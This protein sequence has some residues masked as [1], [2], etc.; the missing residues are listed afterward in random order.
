MLFLVILFSVKG[1]YYI[2]I[3]RLLNCSC[4]FG[5]NISFFIKLKYLLIKI[6][7]AYQIINK[8]CFYYNLPE[9]VY[10]ASLVINVCTS[11]ERNS[12]NKWK[13]HIPAANVRISLKTLCVEISS[14]FRYGPVSVMR[15]VYTYTIFGTACRPTDQKPS[16]L[17]RERIYWIFGCIAEGT[18]ICIPI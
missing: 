2:S 1:V 7:I 10:T 17:L 3:S 18:I 11:A 12:R 4:S 8:F 13:E 6:A 15:V 5:I 16:N 9:I 14:S